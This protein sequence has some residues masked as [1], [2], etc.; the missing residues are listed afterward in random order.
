MLWGADGFVGRHYDVLDVW[1]SYAAQLSG[2]PL[3]GGHFVPEQSP[4][5]T[6]AALRSF[7]EGEQVLRSARG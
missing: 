5:Q 2:V 7:L 6:L 3:P 4:S 1:S